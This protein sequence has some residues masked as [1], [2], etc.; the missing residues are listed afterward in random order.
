MV[1]RVDSAE[2]FINSNNT[3]DLDYVY[4]ELG[5]LSSNTNTPENSVS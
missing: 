2:I 4:S 3:R 5:H 1:S